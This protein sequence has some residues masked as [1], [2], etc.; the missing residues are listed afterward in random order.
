MASRDQDNPM[1]GLLRRSLATTAPAQGECPGSDLLA[2]YYERS[3]GS[4]EMSHCE[5]H[6]SHCATCREQLA[7][8]ARAEALP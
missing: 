3:L 4:D 2:A 7:A 8:M 1:A 6:V 5:D